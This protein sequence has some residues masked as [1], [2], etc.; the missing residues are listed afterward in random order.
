[1][2]NESLSK[3]LK[4]KN[5]EKDNIMEP[6]IIHYNNNFNTRG[7]QSWNDK[8]NYDQTKGWITIT[9]E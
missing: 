9:K 1:M 2:L 3:E 8:E 5:T 6:K 4:K 7:K